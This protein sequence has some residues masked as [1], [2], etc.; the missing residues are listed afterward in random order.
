MANPENTHI[1]I[2][3]AEQ[4]ILGT[5]VCMY[6]TTLNEKQATN[7]KKWKGRYVEDLEGTKREML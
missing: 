3:Q 6:V 1:S 2:V 7:L 4:V 5:Y